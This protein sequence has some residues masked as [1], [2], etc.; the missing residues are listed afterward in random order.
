MIL[1]ENSWFTSIWFTIDIISC[2]VS[3]YL[4]AYMGTFGG[5]S[6]SPVGDNCI[7]VFNIVFILSIIINFSTEYKPDGISKPIRDIKKIA[8]RYLNNGFIMDFLM[9]LPFYDIFQ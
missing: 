6:L 8:L 2:I 5:N 4:Y 1:K 9:V 7:Q 3:S